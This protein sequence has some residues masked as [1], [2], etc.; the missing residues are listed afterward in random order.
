MRPAEAVRDI[1]QAIAMYDPD[2]HHP[3]VLVW[4]DDIGVTSQL[5]L[6]LAH[7]TLGHAARALAGV[8]ASVALARRLAHPFSLCFALATESWL[9]WLRGDRAALRGAAE[10]T[11]ALSAAH[12]FLLWLGNGRVCR[13]AAVP[14]TGAVAEASEGLALMAATGN[15]ASLP[16]HAAMLAE[17]QRTAAQRAE[18]M[19]TVE[20]ALAVAAATGQPFW[21]ADL[22]RLKG[23][24]VLESGG[25]ASEA[26]SLFRQAIAIAREQGARALELRAATSL[27]RA[28]GARGSPEEVRAV[29]EPVYG[30][31][32]EGFDTRDLV[33]ARALLDALS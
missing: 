27:A 6:A 18:A 21:D 13:A 11:L 1:D 23:E 24:L 5:Y 30:T 32:T 28:L 17:V 33:D 26:E 3:A 9:H 12:G 15:Q 7:W 25:A 22:T 20:R 8:R 16:L 14:G 29:L 31:F 2:R 4:G 10:E 19:A